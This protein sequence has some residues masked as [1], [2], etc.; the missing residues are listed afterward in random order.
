MIEE[1]RGCGAFF[2]VV[3]RHAGASSDVRVDHSL[4]VVM[5]RVRQL[6]AMTSPRLAKGRQSEMGA[7]YAV[8]F[9]TRG[10]APLLVQPEV[11][12]HV[13]TQFRL[14]DN[15]G[16]SRTHAWVV[17]PDHVHWL[18]SLRGDDLASCVRCFKS[19]SAR[20][21][22][23]QL[24]AARPVWQ[25]GYF[26]HRIRGFD[27][28]MSQARYIIHNPVRAGLVGSARDYPYWGCRWISHAD[29]ALL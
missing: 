1:P 16:F 24:G 2:V 15:E 3:R 20:A 22:N 6:A 28:L 13:I 4:I 23:L 9:A 8:T 7:A 26:D 14:S 21:I 11:A 25:A 19:R 12:R 17:M 5:L 27:D 18:F 29:S 10:R